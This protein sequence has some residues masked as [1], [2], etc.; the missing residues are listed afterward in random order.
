MPSA[1]AQALVNTLRADP[2]LR[3]DFESDAEAVMAEYVL[4]EVDRQWLGELARQGGLAPATPEV[5]T[6]G[7]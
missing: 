6:P 1:R 4:D 7:F 2:G 3:A 5:A